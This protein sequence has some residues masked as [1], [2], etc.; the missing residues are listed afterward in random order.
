MGGNLVL[1]LQVWPEYFGRK[2]VGA[3]TGTAQM[4]MGVAAAGGPLVVA[5]L[6][7]MSGGYTVPLTA[8]AVAAAAGLALLTITGRPKRPPRPMQKL[9]GVA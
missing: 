8:M 7:D 5:L 6:L 1:Q 4:V 2:A 3:I 9:T